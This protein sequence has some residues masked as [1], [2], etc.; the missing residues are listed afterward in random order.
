MNYITGAEQKV[1]PEAAINPRRHL[2][3]CQR[4]AQQCPKK[5]VP[6]L[7][8]SSMLSSPAHSDNPATSLQSGSFLFPGI[9]GVNS[10]ILVARGLWGGLCGRGP[11]LPCTSH[12]R[13]QQVPQQTRPRPKLSQWGESVEPLNQ[14]EELVAPLGEH[15]EK[16]GNARER[17]AAAMEELVTRLDGHQS[18]GKDYG[19]RSSGRV[20]NKE[21]EKETAAPWP[22]SLVPPLT[23]P[24][25][26]G[27]TRSSEGRERCLWWRRTRQ[28]GGKGFSLGVSVLVICV[29]R[30]VIKQL[31]L[32]QIPWVQFILPTTVIDEWSP[33]L[34]FDPQDFWLLFVRFVP[35]PTVGK[36]RAMQVLCS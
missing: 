1:S 31:K 27:V 6:W 36:E 20:R 14:S 13:F 28:R 24:R 35:R 2:L 3:T 10:H 33:C 29:S 4:T 26:G 15:P 21:Q 7:C 11:G 19:G 9:L 12:S 30:S 17:N 18:W 25:G 32:R 22:W 23:S 8:T 5:R 16:A 34:Y